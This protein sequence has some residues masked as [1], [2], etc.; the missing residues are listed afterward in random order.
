MSAPRIPLAGVIGH[1]VAHSRSPRLHGHW[2]ARHGLPGHYVPLDVAPADLPQVL[3]ALPRAGFVGVNVTLPHKEAALAGAASADAAARAI[4]AANT[5]TFLP[6]G[7][8]HAQNT[9]APGFLH[10]LDQAAPG[11]NTA[12]RPALVLGAGGAARAVLHALLARGTPRILL[13]N[14]SLDRA[15]DLAKAFGDRVET[16]EWEARSS[17]VAD[18]SVIVNTTSLG[19]SGQPPLV[20]DLSRA[21]AGVVVSDLV[22]TPLETDL[23]AQARA[24]RLRPVD[25]LGMLLHQAVPG[26]ARWFG[27]EPVVDEALR[28]AV[29]GP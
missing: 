13:A 16:I 6:G 11:W 9:D 10:N 27:L 3:A 23:L 26:F 14:R 7:G 22:Y 4:G 29:L 19:M 12:D 25:G 24:R 17:A 18:A 28:R 1:P 20:I 21:V 2:L 5:L 8:Y 15:A